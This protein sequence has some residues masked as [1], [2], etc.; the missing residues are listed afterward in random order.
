MQASL[1]CE[2]KICETSNWSQKKKYECPIYGIAPH[3]PSG[4]YGIFVVGT[5]CVQCNYNQDL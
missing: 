2:T 3:L 1:F 4:Y 5:I